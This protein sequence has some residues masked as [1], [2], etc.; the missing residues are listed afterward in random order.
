MLRALNKKSLLPPILFCN[1][2]LQS[3]LWL[4]CSPS[5]LLCLSVCFCLT[6]TRLRYK[7]RCPSLTEKQTGSRNS[8]CHINCKNCHI[9]CNALL[10]AYFCHI[11]CN[12]QHLWCAVRCLYVVSA[13]CLALYIPWALGGRLV[14]FLP[15]LPFS[16]FLSL[17]DWE[18]T[19]FHSVKKINDVVHLLFSHSTF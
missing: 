5:V 9:N 17:E 1:V 6:Y 16:F 2:C 13:L 14:W 3:L 12:A 4:I 19:A 10:T 7:V 8:F 11:N 15:L 18:N